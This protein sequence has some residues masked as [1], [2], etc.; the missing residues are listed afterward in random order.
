[1]RV[2]NQAKQA[3]I[4]TSQN[5]ILYWQLRAKVKPLHCS[6][7]PLWQ[8]DAICLSIKLQEL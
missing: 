5:V 6:M 7:V 2:K 3:E 1:M 4:N 8:S